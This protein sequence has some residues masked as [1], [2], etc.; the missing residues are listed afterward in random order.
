MDQADRGRLIELTR[1]APGGGHCFIA[2]LADVPPGDREE[3]PFGSPLVLFEDGI[4]LGPPHSLHAG[5]REA[6]GGRYSHWKDSLYLSASDNS[7]PRVN[8]RRYQIYVPAVRS[9]AVGRALASL[10]ALAE[11]YTPAEAYAAV[12]RC[13]AALYP[14][15]K[16]GEDL[17]SFW[18]ERE[19]ITAY[20]MLAGDNYRALERKWTV[21]NLL[22][23]LDSVAGDVAECGVYNGATAYFLALGIER[24]GRRRVLHLFDSFAGLSQP[25]AADGSFWRAGTLAC[26]EEVAR[27]N[28][29]RFSD[30]RF[31]RGWIPVQFPA[32]AGRQF[33]FVHVDVDLYQP[34]RDS[35]EFFFPRLQAGGMLV[36]DDYGFDSC[37]GA[38][39]ALDEYF[40]GRPERIVHL[41]TGQGLVIKLDPRAA[42]AN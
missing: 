27:G 36:C 11:G 4:A 8:R 14:A 30:V 17:K 29:A 25:G 42:A 1:F 24:G 40:A 13:L 26:P 3:D 38:R 35:V 33:C 28:L 10:D 22:K 39:R 37:P 20:R 23:A 2:P 34:T 15:A 16:I 21:Y 19:F 6:G 12:E 7:D 9:G 41:P 18:N 32:V 31:Y 5:I